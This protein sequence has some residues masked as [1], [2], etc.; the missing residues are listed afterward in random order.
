[1][2]DIDFSDLKQVLKDTM[3][4]VR[5]FNRVIKA[6]SE[7][8]TR[9]LQIENEGS[10][11]SL[12]T[13]NADNARQQALAILQTAQMVSARLD[14]IDFETN[15]EAFSSERKITG[16][17][18]G[19]FDKARKMLSPRARHKSVRISM[20]GQSRKKSEFYP[21]FDILPFLL[22]ENAV[23]YAPSNSEIVITVEEYQ[24]SIDVKIS[25]MGPVIEKDELAKIVTKG[26]RALEAKKTEEKGSGFGLYFAKFVADLHDASLQF[27][28]ER[29]VFS[30]NGT[31]YSSFQ[32]I[33]AFPA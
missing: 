33:L 24:K 31:R 25:S 30:I 27:T 26:F 32:A 12:N 8:L 29:D 11:L 21:V 6:N 3:H 22:L 19:K 1:M 16:S 4:E 5:E 20:N 13:Q 23:K 17:V 7:M 2:N 10:A 18:Y 14:L 9:L 15:P 28:S